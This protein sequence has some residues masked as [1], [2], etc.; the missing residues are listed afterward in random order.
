MIKEYHTPALLKET[1]EFLGPEPGGVFVDGTLGGGGHALAILD[2]LKGKGTLIGIDR[3]KDAILE[4]EKKLGRM[5]GRLSLVN[6]NFSNIK[7]IL[8]G[9]N[10]PFV[11]G[12]LL[13]LGVSSRQIDSGE[14]GFSLKADGPLDMRMDPSQKISAKDIVNDLDESA[15]E[16]IIREFGEERS[17]RRIARSIVF[18]REH[19]PILTTFDLKGAIEDAL[20]RIPPQKILDSLTRTFQAI[21]IAVN[22][23]LVNLSKALKDSVS[24]LHTGGRIV[25]ISYHS[26]EDR[27][28]K[29][30]FREEATGCICPPRFPKCVCDHK[31]RLNILT[32]KPVTPSE[33]EIKANPRSRSAKL[34]AAE[35]V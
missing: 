35:R 27:M 5:N 26:L 15:L 11:D 22:D 19:K 10:I 32:K 3:D 4:S 12:I 29:T 1:I 24:C 7:E 8:G 31:K 30:I 16:R 18:R 28:V 34:R 14:R 21:R 13:D 23:E 20:G 33:A 17:A 2:K 6:D 9:L 25:V